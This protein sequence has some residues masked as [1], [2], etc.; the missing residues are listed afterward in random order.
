MIGDILDKEII[1]ICYPNDWHWALSAEYINS[2]IMQGAK[3]EVIDLSY[4]A[5]PKP[6]TLI[7]KMLRGSNLERNIRKYFKQKNIIYHKCSN[8]YLKLWINMLSLKTLSQIIDET[9]GGLAYNSIVEKTGLLSIKVNEHKRIVN[10]ELIKVN[11]TNLILNKMPCAEKTTIVTANGRFTK[12]ACVLSFAKRNNFQFKLL[13]FGSNRQKFEIFF[14]SPHSMFEVQ[15]KITKY[16][17]TS[18]RKTRI[19][20]AESFINSIEHKHSFSPYNFRKKMVP[21]K[22]PKFDNR[23]ILT[24][25]ASTESEYAGVRD[26]VGETEFSNQYDAFSAIVALLDPLKWKICLRLH[27]NITGDY[28]NGSETENWFSFQKNSNVEIILPDSDIDSIALGLNSDVVVV[29]A[30][31][32]AMELLSLGQKKIISMGPAPWN[33]LLPDLYVSNNTKLEHFFNNMSDFQGNKTDI[34]PWA[35]YM[36]NFGNDFSILKFDETRHSWVMR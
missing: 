30:S 24:F 22:I 25:F 33:K 1:F 4:I 18:D 35:Y 21:S 14:N 7:R 17:E 5:E 12:N 2:R 29:F 3:I 16:W 34:Y 11:L 28:S 8:S 9:N 10:E 31:V 6:K 20:I 32:I 27:P 15:E 36:S 19:Q 23:K 13:E 26:T